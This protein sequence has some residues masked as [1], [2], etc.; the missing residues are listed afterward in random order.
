ML[1]ELMGIIEDRKRNPSP[2]SYTSQLFAEGEDARA[3][4][5][6]WKKW[7][8]C[9]ITPWCCSPARI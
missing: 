7:L 6:W 1:N 9:S 4:G 2:G 3:K 8:T 5:A